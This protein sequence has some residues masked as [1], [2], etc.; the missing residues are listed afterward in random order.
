[1]SSFNYRTVGIV[2]EMIPRVTYEDEIVLEMSVENST[3]GQDVNIGGSNLPTFSARRVNAKLRLRDGEPNLL[4]GLIR[5]SDR[6]SLRG[7][8]GILRVPIIKQLFSANEATI[9]QTDI[10]IL[11]TPRIVRTHELTQQDVDP[12]F[13]GTSSNL[14]LTGA[15]PVI[16]QPPPATTGTQ[17][18][19]GAQA[20]AA[21]APAPANQ[22]ATQPPAAPAAAATAVAGASAAGGRILLTPNATEVRAGTDGLLVPVTVTDTA[23]LSRV[24]LTVTYNPAA[25]LIRGV[26]QGSF[27]EGG[28]ARVTFTEDHATPGRVDIVIIRTGDTVGAAGTGLLAAL[29]FDTV[30]PGAANLSITGTASVPGG[31]TLPVQFAQT[32]PVLVK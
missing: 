14:G 29:Q 17:P 20:P 31:G 13:I 12:I 26:Q 3:R 11:L 21:P 8:P 23:R 24:S 16:V 6:R 19:A 15:P 22:G 28:G 27:M 5:E 25:L 10:I 9:E 18:P 30:G 1:L 32:A 4:A 7:L 2:L